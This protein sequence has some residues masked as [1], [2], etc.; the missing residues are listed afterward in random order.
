[1]L[2]W[3][4]WDYFPINIKFEKYLPKHTPV[5]FY[6]FRFFSGQT[7]DDVIYKELPDNLKNRI[8]Y[9]K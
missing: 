8:A 2:K 1:M 9:K 4:F 3:T 6:P 5:D 7:K